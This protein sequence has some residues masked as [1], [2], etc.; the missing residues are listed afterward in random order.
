MT[1]QELPSPIQG[2]LYSDTWGQG[3]TLALV[4]FKR[5]G[6]TPKRLLIDKERR[7][8][9]YKAPN[10][11][12]RPTKLQYSFDY[13]HE[14]YAEHLDDGEWTPQALIQLYEDIRDGKFKYNVLLIDNAAMVRKIWWPCFWPA[15]APLTPRHLLKPL[16]V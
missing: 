16:G 8:R 15:M 5:P 10:G 1:E 13:F 12:D 2:V 3:K 4:S 14:L 7:A 11:R 9:S 6:R